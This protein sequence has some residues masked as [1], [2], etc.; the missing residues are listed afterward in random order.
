MATGFLKRGLTGSLWLTLALAAAGCDSPQPSQ[1]KAPGGSGGERPAVSVSQ[2]LKRQIVEWDEYTGR[3]DAVAMVEVR[4]RVSGH[5]TEVHFK[6]GQDVKPGDLLYEIDPRPF[7]RVLDQA[8][9]ELLQAQTRVDN[10]NLDVVRGKPLLDRRVISE[11]TFDDRENLV[12][13]AQAQVKVAEA[14]VKAAE[15]DLSFARIEAPIQGR[16][17]RSMVTAGNWVSGG[18]A[19]NSTMLTSIVSQDPIYIYFDVSE[20]NY[21]KYKRLAERGESAGAADLGSTVELAMPDERGF[22]H[23]G[24]LDFL[25]NRLDQGTGTLRARAVVA[26]AAGFFAPGM[27]ARVRVTGTAPY[28]ALLIPD[29]A[30]GTDQTNKYVYVVADNGQVARRNIQLGPLIDGLR[31]AREGVADGDWVITKGL[32]RARP[33]QSV[34]PNRVALT[35]SSSQ[36]PA[37]T[38]ASKVPQ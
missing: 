15:L 25:D 16:I 12:R 29:E 18:G 34:T 28:P 4:A 7:E 30:I 36:P 3:F 6:D 14:K 23:R 26:N 17:S 8:R 11:K 31:V 38:P 22:P 20:N 5:L 24:K 9:A 19:S 37:G 1:A 21:I 33:G 2:P 32:H 13:D 10:A 35:L 27:F